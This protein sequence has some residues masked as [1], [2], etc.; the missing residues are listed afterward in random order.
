[1]YYFVRRVPKALLGYY[2]VDK[3]ALS[4][5][6]KSIAVAKSR[7]AK[8]SQQLD[9]EWSSLS[10]NACES[11]L[12]RFRKISSTGITAAQGPTISEAKAV[13]LKQVGIGRSQTFFN[14]VE[15]AANCLIE[16][17]GDKPID[18]ISRSDV[19]NIRDSLIERGL[20]AA[21]VKRN[22]STLRALI[23]FTCREFGLN[24]NPSFASVFLPKLESN[25]PDR[26]PIPLATIRT[27]QDECR[28]L[29]DEAR[30][31]IALLSDTG[32]RLSEALGLHASD[33]VTQNGIPSLSIQESRWRPLKTKS[34][35]RT[36]PLVGAALWAS[37]RLVESSGNGFLFTKY[38][39]GQITKSNSASAALNKWL[40]PRVPDGCV[41]HSF[42]HSFR[43]RLRAVECPAEII[44]QLGGWTQGTIGARYGNGFS[45]S[46]I[47][48]WMKL[49][50][51][52]VAAIEIH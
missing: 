31:L 50:E 27:I 37:E 36:I 20:T 47:A 23:W 5:R 16:G 52:N 10:W 2:S 22:L 3:I 48:S 46:A 1:M 32:V 6:T 18:A 11:P 39:D 44:D 13:Y 35:T 28:Q 14:S 17:C 30:W 4:L 24:Q 7:A 38:C 49:L 41:I 42:R 43:D 40:K 12:S 19:N 45:V 21:S 25:R 9:D 33:I 8:L 51:T 26:M 34:S 15:R 29:D